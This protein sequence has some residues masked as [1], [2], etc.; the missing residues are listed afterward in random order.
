MAPPLEHQAE[1]APLHGPL[2][3]ASSDEEADIDRH[4]LLPPVTSSSPSSVYYT[5]A[6]YT[7]FASSWRHVPT[8]WNVER[9]PRIA[10][11]QLV[12]LFSF[13]SLCIFVFSVPSL[14]YLISP[15]APTPPGS[16]P[17][18]DEAAST[19]S[20]KI[21]AVAADHPICSELGVKIMR[22]FSGNAVDAMVSTVL[23]QGVLAPFASGLGGGAFILIHNASSSVSSF[24]DARETA[25][26]AAT[27]SLYERNATTAKFG[28]LAVAI[29]GELRGLHMAHQEW[30]RLT[31]KQVV[32]PVVEVA[33]DAKVGPF[34][35]IK[36]RQMH[37]TIM[38]SPS[39]RE[40]FT[41]KVLTKKAQS[42]QNAAASVELPGVRQLKSEEGVVS[43]GVVETLNDETVV[44]DA[45]DKD[46]HGI[47]PKNDNGEKANA[48]YTTELLKEGDR[49]ENEAL[50]NTLKKIAN[51]G[52]DA[53][54]VDMAGTLAKEIQDAGGVAKA[55][56]F[57]GYTAVKRYPVACNYHGFQVI[58]APLPSAGGVSIAM[59]LNMIR[60]LRFRKRGRNSV[61]Y[62]MLTET[63]KWVYGARMG[64]GDPSYVQGTDR[65][66]WNMLSRREAVK[67]VFRI[68][69]DRTF[70][71]RFY[72]D[73]ITMS[74]LEGGTSHVSILDGNGTGVSVTS[75]IN[76]PFGA[77]LVSKSGGMVFNDE[78]DAFT[79]SMTRLN[80]FGLYPSAENG[81][82]GGKRAISSMSPTILVRNGQV[83]MVI[84]AS[85]GPKAVSGV[86]QTVLNVVDFGDELGDAISAPRL[87]HQLVPNEVGLEGANGTT[88]EL[89]HVLMKPSGGKGWPYWTSVCEGL[90]EAGHKV[91][92]PGVH[93]AVQAVVAPDVVLSK[94]ARKRGEGEGRIY[95]ASDPRRIGKAA[96]Y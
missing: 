37:E 4:G 43:R 58:G 7:H 83:F 45:N 14:L 6:L 33:E 71:P 40:I 54:Y 51:K 69:Q 93:G 41:K 19:I 46:E 84:G 70:G 66:V 11:T 90:K 49:I 67:R 62:K 12:I 94:R 8:S 60:E 30:G 82:E 72:S 76:L 5:S 89:E 16:A 3:D 52:P 20:G 13:L 55:D 95:A 56:D 86:L 9:D 23:C 50:V 85:G 42:E 59:A 22:D 78:M 32:D 2:P 63:L 64:L 73:R 21:G 26:A 31:W 39:L 74:N 1:P 92:G 53:L 96:A 88:C 24:Y 57:K 80:A 87:H 27:M 38:A 91:R 25:P 34:L 65:Q 79:T 29:P 36:L 61:S 47:V 48:T 28:G 68:S 81:V 10:F 15:Q 75:T 77:G 18:L 17:D 44:G 35:E